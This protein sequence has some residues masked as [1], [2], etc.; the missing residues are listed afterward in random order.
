MG[1]FRLALKYFY[2]GFSSY[3]ILK[4]T[5]NKNNP[6]P[7]MQENEDYNWHRVGHDI[8]Y[9]IKQLNKR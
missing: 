5:I 4:S 1:L 8:E 6:Y 7:F 2:Y 9:S 3:A